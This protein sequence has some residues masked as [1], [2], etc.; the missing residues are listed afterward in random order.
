MDEALTL[1]PA[2]GKVTPDAFERTGRKTTCAACGEE[3]LRLFHKTRDGRPWPLPEGRSL[4]T[5][6]ILSMAQAG[7]QARRESRAQPPAGAGREQG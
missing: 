3:C 5:F 4:C 1:L 2:P 7:R 6:C